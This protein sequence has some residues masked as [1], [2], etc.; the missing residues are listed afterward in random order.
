VRTNGAICRS[1][2]SILKAQ[3]QKA[4]ENAEAPDDGA[5]PIS[6]FREARTLI[7]EAGRQLRAKKRHRI[8]TQA[9]RE[10]ASFNGGTFLQPKSL[11]RN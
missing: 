11:G 1:V 2:D 9:F 7:G 6:A 8:T 5:E 4:F 10:I 3:A